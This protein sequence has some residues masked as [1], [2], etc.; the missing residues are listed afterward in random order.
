MFVPVCCYIPPQ[1][2]LL[3]YDARDDMVARMGYSTLGPLPE[4]V[5][6]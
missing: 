3:G 2:A 6:P 1:K 5:Y 4:I